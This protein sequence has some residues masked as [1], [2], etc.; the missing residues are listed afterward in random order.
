MLDNNYERLSVILALSYITNVMFAL[1]LSHVAK[2]TVTNYLC[3]LW[4]FVL[5]CETLSHLFRKRH[6]D[7]TPQYAQGNFIGVSLMVSV[8]LFLV[9]S[10]YL[11]TLSSSPAGYAL[12]GDVAEYISVSIAFI[13]NRN[14]DATYIW[15]QIFIGIAS[16]LTGL[17][18][19]HA[20]VGLQFLIIL[21]PLSFYTFML[22]IFD[23][24][25]IAVIGTVIT[26]VTDG[27]T[28]IGI[29]GLFQEY[30]TQNLFSILWSLRVKTQN[31]PWLSNHFFIV[32]TMDWSLL[33]LAFAFIYAYIIKGKQLSQSSDLILG[34]IFLAST[35]FTHSAIGIVIFIMSTFIFI[36][37]HHKCIRRIIISFIS[38][39]VVMIMFDIMSYNFLTNFITNYYL[40]Y[41]LLFASPLLFP[42]QSR[43][44]TLLTLSLALTL[45]FISIKFALKKL[46]ITKRIKFL[47]YIPLL[48]TSIVLVISVISIVMIFIQFS[49]INYPTETIF[50][51]YIYVIRFTPFLQLGIIFIPS[52]LRMKNEKRNEIWIMMSWIISAFLTIGLHIFFPRFITSLLVNRILMSIYFPLGAL[53]AL[54][55]AFLAQAKIPKIKLRFKKIC[56]RILD[57]EI[58]IYLLMILIGSSFLSHAYS[59]EIFYQGNM[60]LS[61]SRDEKSLYEYL[62]NLPPEATFLTY[63]YQMY[64]CL[65]SLTTHK[66]YAYYQYGAFT[67]W[68]IEILFNTSSPEVACYF[69]YKLGITHIVF[70]KQDWTLLSKITDSA[71]ISMLNFLPIVFNNSFAIVY[72][73]PNYTH[74]ELSNYVL[75]KPETYYIPTVINESLAYNPISLNNLRIV[76]GPPTFRIENDTIVQEVQNIKTPSAQY[77]QLYKGVTISTALSSIVS[78]RVRG[79]KNALFNVGFFDTKKGW[80]WLS[81]EW[82]LPN[83]FFNT[84]ND[85][86][87][88]KVNL[89]SIFGKDA[90]ILYIDFVATSMDGSPARVEWEDFKVFQVI[91][92]NELASSLYKVAYN[93]LAT[94]QIPFTV[95]EDYNT[96]KLMPSHIYIFPFSLPDSISSADFINYVATGSHTI[97]LYYPITFNENLNELL[98]FLGIKLGG[99]DPANGIKINDENFNFSSNLYVANFTINSPYYYKV[100][101]HYITPDSRTIPF[102]VLFKIEN[103]SLIFINMPKTFN[104]DRAVANIV[105]NVIKRAMTL[106]PKPITSSI[107]KVMSYPPDLF[108]LGNPSLINIYKL[109]GLNNYIYTFSNIELKGNI[110]I[111][112][113]YVILNAKNMIIKKLILQNTAYQEAYENI[114]LANLY[115]SGSYNTTLVTQNTVIYNLGGELFLIEAFPRNLGIY[116]EGHVIKLAIKQNGI[117]KNLTISNGYVEFEFYKNV[118]IKLRFQK[119][120]VTLD[121][122]SLD[123][124]WKGVFWYN[125]RI[126]TTVATAE[127]FPIIGHYS[128]QI[129]ND[130]MLLIKNIKIIFVEIRPATYWEG[131]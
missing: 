49:Y 68:P 95:I 82:V 103:G 75:V 89:S 32:A 105:M 46:K 121:G 2:L 21:F 111:S 18:P 115:I 11:I 3:I 70:T 88:I 53:S 42:Y 17:H 20:F 16:V 86:I 85:W 69:L 72:S 66:T 9:F 76:G 47:R 19:L 83:K 108:K 102:T 7:F 54:T 116:I 64:R 10:S 71:L 96:S 6:H 57:K 106:L 29:L 52:I 36:F 125:G 100:I 93:S 129:I 127:R 24:H 62:E 112:S 73:I 67:S 12:G 122:G 14:F 41:S 59:I 80:Y 33:M 60:T 113:N 61:L 87:E 131:G 31:W 23:D 34:S 4:V 109:N 39:S 40:H 98:N 8:C 120:L 48:C 25:K 104:L 119:P 1:F 77:L 22:K 107:L 110:S 90:T 51:W 99:I 35:F 94:I 92:I 44:I 117:E 65:S 56:V 79:T 5:F 123:V 81:N 78:F 84:S 74:S 130:N 63:S 45:F 124:S 58:L 114:S 26:T 101:S 38:I 15:F 91:R 97:I 118:T 50:P 28:W 13:K 128:F 37:L 30:N 55:L 43:I 126:F 27:L